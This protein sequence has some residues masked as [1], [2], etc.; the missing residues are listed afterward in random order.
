MIEKTITFDDLDGKSVTDTFHFNLND[1]EIAEL[2]MSRKGLDE[3]LREIIK[4][5]DIE[6]L[7]VLFK[8]LLSMAVGRRINNRVFE[9]SPAIVAEFM[10]SGAYVEFF[11]E[12]IAQ[13]AYAAEFI[14]EMAPKNLEAR[15]DKILQGE[16]KR[17]Y[18]DDE[19][20]GMSNSEFKKVAGDNPKMWSQ[21]FLAIAYQRKMHKA[22]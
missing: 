10:N 3:Y 22:A 11:F 14:K 15:I 13:P 17:E 2:A 20:L 6:K 9:K 1:A 8:E 7:M 12:L 18:T 5:E 21:R 16:E 19:L 4:T